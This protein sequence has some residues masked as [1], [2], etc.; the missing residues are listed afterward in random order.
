MKQVEISRSRNVSHKGEKYYINF[1]HVI[2]AS[3]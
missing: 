2:E 3:P 1:G